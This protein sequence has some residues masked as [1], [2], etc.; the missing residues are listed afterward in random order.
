MTFNFTFGTN[1]HSILDKTSVKSNWM[2]DSFLISTWRR[3]IKNGLLRIWWLKEE[4]QIM[5]F[6]T[7]LF[8]CRAQ[9]EEHYHLAVNE[10]TKTFIKYLMTKQKGL[11]S[12]KKKK[13]AWFT[14]TGLH[15]SPQCPSVS[16]L[17]RFGT[18][19]LYVI[20]IFFLNNKITFIHF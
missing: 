13:S 17:S 11:F 4:P 5:L 16:C 15:N 20:H 8:P 1:P 9:C 3:S 2:S 19:L 7:V 12:E 14:H 10:D 6:L 18:H